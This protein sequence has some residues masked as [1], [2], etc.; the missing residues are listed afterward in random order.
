MRVERGKRVDRGRR[1]DRGRRGGRE[2]G[3]RG[4]MVDRRR[5]MER[6]KRVEGRRSVKRR[7]GREGKE[8]GVREEGG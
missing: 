5:K 1:M 7:M 3:E 8:G 2:E 4:E 6:G